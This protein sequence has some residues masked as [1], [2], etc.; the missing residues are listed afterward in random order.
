MYDLVGF[1]V[2]AGGKQLH[3]SFSTYASAPSGTWFCFNKG[4]VEALKWYAVDDSGQA[5]SGTL[6]LHFPVLLQL[7]SKPCRHAWDPTAQQST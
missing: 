3:S 1:M 4:Q 2:W 7:L 6:K 5:T